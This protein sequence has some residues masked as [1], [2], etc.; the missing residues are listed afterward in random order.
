MSER[1]TIGRTTIGIV[2]A[3]SCAIA[4]GPAPAQTSGPPAGPTGR[5]YT[6]EQ[7][8]AISSPT[9]YLVTSAAND[10]GAFFWIV[11]TIEKKVTLCEKAGASADFVCNKKP[12]P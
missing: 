9:R 5:S 12:L 1:R 4:T 2:V 10:H 7:L 6:P 3:V 8:G 11:D